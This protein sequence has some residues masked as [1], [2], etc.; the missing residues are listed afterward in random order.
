[1]NKFKGLIIVSIIIIAYGLIM[2][3]IFGGV[4]NTSNNDNNTNNTNS[5]NNTSNNNVNEEAKYLVVGNISNLSYSN[6]TFSKTNKSNIE[7]LDKLKVYVN[8]NYYGDYKFKSGE[9]WNLFDKNN[10]YVNYNGNLLAYSDNFNI[11]VR[12]KYK[13]RTID[14]NDKVFLINNYNINSFE[15]LTTNEAID[16]DLDNDGTKDEII[17][18]SSMEESNNIKNYYNLLVLKLNNEKVT[19]IEEREKDAKYVYDIYGIINVENSPYDS[20]IL[21]KTEGYISDNPKVSS[22]IYNYKNDKYMID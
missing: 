14:E 21:T 9:N 18:L 8:N 3:F 10:A 5:N 17:C 7:E 13:I 4:N 11:K 12:N 19:L 22:L 16:I 1:M 6:N 15:Y 20:I 2:Y